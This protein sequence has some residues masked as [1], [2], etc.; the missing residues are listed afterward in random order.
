MK[1]VVKKR[2]LLLY[3][4]IEGITLTESPS[5]LKKFPAASIVNFFAQNQNNKEA[6]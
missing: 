4:C 2:T 5:T 3:K 1:I 6:D